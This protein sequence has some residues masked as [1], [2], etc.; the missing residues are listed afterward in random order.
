MGIPLKTRANPKGLFIER[1]FYD[2]LSLL[3]TA[4]LVNVQPRHCW[5]LGHGSKALA[6][7]IQELI[8][9]SLDEAAPSVSPPFLTKINPGILSELM[10]CMWCR[11]RRRRCS[12]SSRRSSRA[13]SGRHRR[14]SRTMRSSRASRRAGARRARSS[15]RSSA[16]RWRTTRLSRRSLTST[17][18]MRPR[19]SILYSEQ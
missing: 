5:T 1:E 8:E 6:P 15:R 14:S 12:P 9:T 4:A 10:Y 11:R 18:T 16:V 7:V 3:F 17:G 19:R 2:T 13:S